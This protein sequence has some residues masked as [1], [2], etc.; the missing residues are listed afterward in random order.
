MPRE[1]LK[2]FLPAR[3]TLDGWSMRRVHINPEL[4]FRDKLMH[5]LGGGTATAHTFF[6][7][8]QGGTGLVL[9]YVHPMPRVSL[10]QAETGKHVTL[11]GAGKQ[12]HSYV[13][14]VGV[15]AD[16][17]Y[18]LVAEGSLDMWVYRISRRPRRC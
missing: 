7:D 5:E 18:L 16:G 12:P 8:G 17:R 14:D 1:E 2:G 4:L 10:V 3:Q 9:G 6:P 15:S 11:F 13:H